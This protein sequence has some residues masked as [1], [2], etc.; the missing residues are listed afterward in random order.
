MSA[1]LWTIRV[2]DLAAAVAV[3]LMLV[4]AWTAPQRAERRFL[5]PMLVGVEAWV[6]GDLIAKS[7]VDAGVV[8]G[9]VLLQLAA[10][11]V[12]VLFL[13]LFVLAYTGREDAIRAPTV[14]LLLVEPVGF[15]LLALTDPIHRL[16]LSDSLASSTVVEAAGPALLVHIAYS[17]VLVAVALSLAGGLLSRAEFVYRRQAI[18]LVVGISAPFLG[19]VLYFFTPIPVDLTPIMFVVTGGALTYAARRADL[20]TLSPM[21]RSAVL[22]AIG[23]GVLVLDRHGA[24]LD[25]NPPARRLLGLDG[26]VGVGRPVTDLP[27]DRPEPL[28]RLAEVVPPGTERG[29]ELELADRILDVRV[30]P[31]YDPRER[32]IGA[33]VVLHDI[34]ERE[35]Q[36]RT[37]RRQRERLDRFAGVVSHDLRN[38][39]S[40]AAGGVSLAREEGDVEQLDAVVDALDRMEHILEDTLALARRGESLGETGAV[41]L[42]E[43]CEDCWGMIDGEGA[44]VEVEAATIRGDRS[45]LRHLFE[46]LF[47]NSVEHGG[48]EVTVRVGTLPDGFYVEDDGPGIPTDRRADVVEVG[49]SVADGGTGLGLAIVKEIAEAHGWGFEIIDGRDGGARF[50]FTGVA[51][52]EE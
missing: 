45:R 12:A 32:P 14:A 3:G 48:E 1:V 49:Y 4:L 10:S 51:F 7:T 24:V 27:T 28:E 6:L 39:L 26:P 52:V 47:R 13:L 15:V 9:A 31:L 37:L 46:N 11:G 17:Y 23:N 38:P 20:L 8:R 19:N 22:D 43:L 2:L 29:F 40:V 16:V 18:A 5:I 50:E 41:D 35:R 34:T 33:V 30:S 44:T 25:S 36:R 42:A 21:A